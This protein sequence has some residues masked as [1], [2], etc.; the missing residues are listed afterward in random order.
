MNVAQKVYDFISSL[1][2]EEFNNLIDEYEKGVIRNGECSNRYQRV[3]KV[4]QSLGKRE[5]KNPE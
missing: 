2:L 1:S 5:Q 3:G 4:S